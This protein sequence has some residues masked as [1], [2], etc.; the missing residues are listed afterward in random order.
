MLGTKAWLLLSGAALILIGI[1]IRWRMARYDLKDAAIDSAWTLA[2]GRRTAENPT[3]LEAKLNDITSQATWTGK[4]TKAA[5]TA[6]GH[7]MAQILGVVALVL[8]L[9]GLVLVVAGFFWG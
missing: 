5:G 8:M 7:V 2:R 9:A 6:A 1:L 4:A 3:A